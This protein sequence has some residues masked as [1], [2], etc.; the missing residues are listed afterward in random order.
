V[1]PSSRQPEGEVCDRR[2]AGLESTTARAITAE[3]LPLSPLVSRR[4][5]A[6]V[7]TLCFR[8]ARHVTDTL[9]SVAV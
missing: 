6:G 2:S 3:Q 8:D 9:V 4:R 1:T 7:E 5:A